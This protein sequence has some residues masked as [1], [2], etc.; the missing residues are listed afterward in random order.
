MTKEDLEGYLAEGLS[1]E[2]IGKR[3]GRDPSTVSHHLRRHGLVPVGHGAHAPNQKVDPDGLRKLMAVGATVRAAAAHFGVGYSTIRYWL[4]RLDI[5]TARM[6]RLRESKEARE[7][8]KARVVL[9]CP[10]HGEVEF[11]RRPDGNYRCSKCR[12][13]SVSAWRRR[14][15]RKLIERAGGRC[16]LCGY[17]RHPAALQFHHV[18]P[19]TKSFTLSRQ[20]VTRSFSEA[21]AEADRCVLLCGNCHAEVE[22]GHVDLPT[23][24]LSLQLAD[25]R[26]S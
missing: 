14:V 5:E 15:K 8:G 26:A 22:A 24:V 19:A 1:L 10:E 20:G 4:K 9:T 2:Q 12:S 7:D 11:F 18:D 13:Q 17:D 21:A 16:V 3:V 6:K 23:E 25:R